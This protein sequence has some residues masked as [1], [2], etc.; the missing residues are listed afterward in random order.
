[1]SLCLQPYEL[2]VSR[3][4]CSYLVAGFIKM[5][6]QTLIFLL[7]TRLA[8]CQTTNVTNNL[9]SVLQENPDTQGFGD[10]LEEFPDLITNL[11][12][13]KQYTVFAPSNDAVA[14]FRASLN[15]SGT[16]DRRTGRLNRRS[17]PTYAARIALLFTDRS[18]QANLNTQPTDLITNLT[19]PAFID[20]TPASTSASL[21][22]S[23][24]STSS[25]SSSIQSTSSSAPSST[26]TVLPTTSSA[27]A[28]TSSTAL[29]TASSIQ[30]PTSRSSSSP[31]PATTSPA[32]GPTFPQ[33]KMITSGK[34]S[35]RQSGWSSGNGTI[36]VFT[37]FG[38]TAIASTTETPYCMGAIR[39]TDE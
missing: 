23:S 18:N 33:G 14:A 16:L 35:R 24:S 3:S 37:G 12:A 10:L 34:K 8:L 26:S 28:I 22:Q 7:A 11:N 4:I 27:P 1:M 13:T 36:T 39:A 31:P 19:D 5:K 17:I 15:S 29:T 2:I 38:K 25:S 9:I 20:I 21:T 30:S 6:L 32:L